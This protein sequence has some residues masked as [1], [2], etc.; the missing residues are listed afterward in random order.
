MPRRSDSPSADS[1]SRQIQTHPQSKW[2][3]S[4]STSLNFRADVLNSATSGSE[5]RF[6]TST[7]PEPGMSPQCYWNSDLSRQIVA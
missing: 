1:R 4:P 5:S 2:T 3:D 7:E 6:S